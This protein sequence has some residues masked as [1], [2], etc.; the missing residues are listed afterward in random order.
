MHF[1]N[2]DKAISEG[3]AGLLRDNKEDS[4][5]VRG[6]YRCLLSYFNQQDH[7]HIH[8]DSLEVKQLLIDLACGEVVPEAQAKDENAASPWP[9]AFKNA[10]LPSADAKPAC[11]SGV[12]AEYAWWNH[13]VAATVKQVTDA[14]AE[15]ASSKGWELVALP[16]SPDNGVPDQLSKLLKG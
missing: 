5:C 11:F 8:R 14:M 3:D 15:D 7:E 4:P 6:C 10:E 1:E 2:I 9:I 13:Y 16:Q 12:E